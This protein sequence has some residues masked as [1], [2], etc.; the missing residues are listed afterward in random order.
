MIHRRFFVPRSNIYNGE[1]KITD[2]VDINHIKKVL[3]LK[4]GDEVILLDGEGKEYK[5]ILSSPT[6][7]QEMRLRLVNP[8]IIHPRP[9]IEFTLIQ[10]LPKNPKMEFIIQK[11]TEMGI[12]RIIPLATSRSISIPKDERRPFIRWQ[13][14]A[15]EAAS[16]CGRA[17]LPLIEGPITWGK[18]LNDYSLTQGHLS[19]LLW[20]EDCKRLRDVLRVLSPLIERVDLFVGPEGGFTQ[21][22]V[23]E[24]HRKGVIPCSLGP[25]LL[26]TETASIVALSII[27]YKLGLV[28]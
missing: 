4:R 15:R 13:K 24:L 23:F 12:T 18:F 16:Q 17:Y 14:I 7:H 2:E 3:R 10:G 9:E 25:Q 19:L 6:S 28:G 22:E 1:A 26:R 20:E 5:A 21:R 8:P 27:F 11:T